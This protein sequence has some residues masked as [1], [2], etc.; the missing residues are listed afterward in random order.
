MFLGS[1]KRE[2]WLPPSEPL[3][4]HSYEPDTATPHKTNLSHT[5][6]APELS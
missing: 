1:R 4:E 3:E 6:L 5:L 2:L